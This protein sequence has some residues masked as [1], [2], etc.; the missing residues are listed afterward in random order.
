MLNIDDLN[1]E[2]LNND[3]ESMEKNI[4]K[5]NIIIILTDEDG[6][7][8]IIKKKQRLEENILKLEVVN[9]I[10]NK[11]NSEY[12]KDEYK[13]NYLLNFAIN[14]NTDTLEYLNNSEKKE[15]IKNITETIYELDI[16]KNLKDIKYNIDN[17]KNNTINFI[18]TNSLIIILKKLEKIH[19]IKKRHNNNNNKTKKRRN[20]Y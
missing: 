5:I 14:T 19:Y 15:D 7:E 9:E 13:I 16:L 2:E 3:L 11:V 20:I 1:I 18:D 6:I 4:S 10:I 17:K 12:C 8:K